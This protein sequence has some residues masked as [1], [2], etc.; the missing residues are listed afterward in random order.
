MRPWIAITGGSCPTQLPGYGSAK[1]WR[2]FKFWIS[3]LGKWDFSSLKERKDWRSWAY[4]FIADFVL[5]IHRMSVLILAVCLKFGTGAR[6]QTTIFMIMF[7]GYIVIEIPDGPIC[8]DHKMINLEP[9]FSSSVIM[10]FNVGFFLSLSVWF[11]LWFK[12][13]HQCLCFTFYVLL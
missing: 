9:V 7:C 4:I 10:P 3:Q 1:A 13:L 12:T 6:S 2:W 8:L 5:H 11:S